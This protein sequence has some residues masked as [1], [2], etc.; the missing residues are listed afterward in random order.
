MAVEHSKHYQQ[1]LTYYRMGMWTVE[2]V[3]NAVKM[4][5]IT[6]GEFEEITGEVYHE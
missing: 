2:R 6:A 4:H 1:V 3:R 5:W